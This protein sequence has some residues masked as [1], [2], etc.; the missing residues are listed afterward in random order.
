MYR[1]METCYDKNGDVKSEM[2]FEE[3]DT[4][5]AAEA[6]SEFLM[7]YGRD[8]SN[9]RHPYKLVKK[10]FNEKYGEAFFHPQIGKGIQ[11]AGDVFDG[12][13]ALEIIEEYGEDIPEYDIFDF[14]NDCDSD[15]SC[16]EIHYWT[17]Y[18]Y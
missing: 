7:Q 3:Y 9:G 10:I 16:G 14:Y 12:P 17:E 8:H 18:V 2:D 11:Y 5:T 4:E 15:C 1:I 13:E 6:I